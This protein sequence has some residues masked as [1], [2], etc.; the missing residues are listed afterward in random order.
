MLRFLRSRT[1][2]TKVSCGV[3]MRTVSICLWGAWLGV[4]VG[5][6]CWLTLAL[7]FCRE[8][9]LKVCSGSGFSPAADRT[10]GSPRRR[11]PR[12]QGHARV[13]TM[14]GSPRRHGHV[15][16]T[17]GSPLHHPLNPYQQG[18]LSARREAH[19]K[20]LLSL[21]VFLCSI[22]YFLYSLFTTQTFHI[23]RQNP[24]DKMGRL[25]V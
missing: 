14:P 5:P 19:G 3:S 11:S 2:R 7:K 18:L 4:W 16:V 24:C 12:R 23:K 10:A 25:E 9:S 17:S 15:R 1:G 21:S 13:I 22:H 8:V 20:T 6:V